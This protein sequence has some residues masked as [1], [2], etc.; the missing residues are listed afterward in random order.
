MTLLYIHSA[1][2]SI[3]IGWGFVFRS[4]AVFQNRLTIWFIFACAQTKLF[5][6]FYEIF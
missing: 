4:I 6:V 2:R 3:N 5:E 1:N